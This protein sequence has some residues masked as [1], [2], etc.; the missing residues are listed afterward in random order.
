MFRLFLLIS[1]LFLSLINSKAMEKEVI[2]LP[3][4]VEEKEIGHLQVIPLIANQAYVIN[5]TTFTS[6][7]GDS[8]SLV[9][10]LDEHILIIDTPY[11]PLAMTAVLNWVKEENWAKDKMGSIKT[12]S[13]INSHH[14]VDCLGGNKAAIDH[15]IDVYAT[16]LTKD[17]FNDHTEAQNIEGMKK[18]FGENHPFLS[19][20][21]F[22]SPNQTLESLDKIGSRL[23]KKFGND[24]VWIMYPG[25][26]HAPD[27][28]VIYI[29]HHKILFGGCM[30]TCPERNLGA[31][32]EANLD[33]WR[34][35]I[36]YV[37]TFT[38]EF[39]PDY[40]ISG[41]NTKGRIDSAIFTINNINRTKELLYN[42]EEIERYNKTKGQ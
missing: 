42:P 29:P 35:A 22:T 2:K 23:E 27:N 32:G 6:P 3:L 20:L 8:F 14:H 10:N 17:R 1:F 7:G 24:S 28:I 37:E 5:D 9:C 26:A 30:I 34:N 25:H 33:S 21:N 41:H 18:Y 36:N 4:C 16:Q 31:L 38:N 15:K 12:I 11:T 40:V 19:Q 39:K 13:V